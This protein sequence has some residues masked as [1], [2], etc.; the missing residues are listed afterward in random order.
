[1]EYVTRGSSSF[2]AQTNSNRFRGPK[3]NLVS[4][5]G[6]CR[7][8]FLDF[9]TNPRRRTLFIVVVLAEEEPQI[10]KDLP[11]DGRSPNWSRIRL[12][13][14]SQRSPSHRVESNL[15]V[16]TVNSGSASG[17]LEDGYVSKDTL[18]HSSNL[19]VVQWLVLIAELQPKAT[20]P[21]YVIWNIERL[22]FGGST[23][24]P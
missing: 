10:F 18:L 3:V 15:D 20:L 23:H 4:N 16:T 8:T 19:L 7:K 14:R 5:S 9:R 6:E 17:S 13:Y 2:E 11:V 21:I 1:M 12:E 24:F 22:T